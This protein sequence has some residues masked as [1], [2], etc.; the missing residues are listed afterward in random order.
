[1]DKTKWNVGKFILF[2]L[3]FPLCD[4]SNEIFKA[5]F[6]GENGGGGV[7]VTRWEILCAVWGAFTLVVKNS[8]S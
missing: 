1:M 7:H 6:E 5:I 2:Y 8:G 4:G 3:Y